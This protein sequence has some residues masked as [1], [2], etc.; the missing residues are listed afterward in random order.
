MKTKINSAVQSLALLALFF[1]SVVF[2]DPQSACAQ[3]DIDACQKEYNTR[4]SQCIADNTACTAACGGDQNC[5]LTCNNQRNACDEAA[6][7]S[8]KKC[9]G[10]DTSGQDLPVVDV[11]PDPA[12]S[13]S[14]QSQPPAQPESEKKSGTADVDAGAEVTID[15]AQLAK[16]RTAISQ[17]A[18]QIKSIIECQGPKLPSENSCVAGK[19]DQL[20][21]IDKA[22]YGAGGSAPHYNTRFIKE[23]SQVIEMDAG[24]IVSFGNEILDPSVLPEV[25]QMMLDERLIP[26]VLPETE[27]A[28]AGYAGGV[29]SLVVLDSDVLSEGTVS[30]GGPA[31]NWNKV[32]PGAE[33]RPGTAIVTGENSTVRLG[34]SDGKVMEVKPGAMIVVAGWSAGD[35][36]AAPKDFFGSLIN[37][38]SDTDALDLKFGTVGTV[39]GKGSDT[40]VKTP[41]TITKSKHTAFAVSYNPEKFYAV[42]VVYKGEVEV[43]N[44]VTGET[45]VLAPTEDGK[46]RAVIVPLPGTPTPAAAEAARAPR[47]LI[48]A[49]LALLLAAAGYLAYRHKADIAAWIGKVK[50]A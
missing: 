1:A 14:D 22:V 33:V 43:T 45:A 5:E 7:E 40:A 48:V 41:L 39:T 35:T 30:V 31:I 44:L 36:L 47:L 10:L 23:F 27:A 9:L 17:E 49:L 2:F 18:R 37:S 26:P 13:P 24:K 16:S 29:A 15:P 4:R 8:Q 42:T 25:E 50:R 34:G 3:A 6:V 12:E 20:L 46:P 38:G 21:E 19:I 32:T 28:R 11:Q